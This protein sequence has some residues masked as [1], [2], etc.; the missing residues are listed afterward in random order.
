MRIFKKWQSQKGKGRGISCPAP[1]AS[2]IAHSILEF[3]KVHER[4][5]RAQHKGLA[6]LTELWGEAPQAIYMLTKMMYKL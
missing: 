3:N 2:Q 1:Y 4:C 5:P 6:A